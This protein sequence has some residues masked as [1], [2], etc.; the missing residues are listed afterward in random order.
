MME[1][2]TSQLTVIILKMGCE[3]FMSV[4]CGYLIHMA[5]I[6]YPHRTKIG[7]T[8]EYAA[9]FWVALHF[10]PI[11]IDWFEA[12]ELDDDVNWLIYWLHHTIKLEMY[13]LR[14]KHMFRLLTF[15]LI[16]F[17][18]T[19]KTFCCLC[20][21]SLCTI[22][23]MKILDFLHNMAPHTGWSMDWVT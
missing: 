3:F 1:K 5:W 7:I 8:V 4:Q 21:A 9:R 6:R 20:F 12:L 23:R 10:R 17:F 19:K 2:R 18:S 16:R 15:A 13:I 14:L 11:S 22:Y